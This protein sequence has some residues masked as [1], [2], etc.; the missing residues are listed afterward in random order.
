MPECAVVL[1]EFKQPI[2]RPD[3][4]PD[5]IN[6][7]CRHTPVALLRFAVWVSKPSWLTRDTERTLPPSAVSED[8]LTPLAGG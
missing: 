6:Q 2:F 4:S 7:V 3:D 8:A 5:Q 1:V